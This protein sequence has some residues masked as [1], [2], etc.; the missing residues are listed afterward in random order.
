MGSHKNAWRASTNHSRERAMYLV[1][2]VDG[3]ITKQGVRI[4]QSPLPFTG[5]HALATL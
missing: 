1:E 3:I 4:I 5:M 2:N